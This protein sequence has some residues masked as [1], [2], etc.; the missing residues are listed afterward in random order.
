MLFAKPSVK[1]ANCSASHA[2]TKLGLRKNDIQDLELASPNGQRYAALTQVTQEQNNG[3]G[4][5]RIIMRRMSMLSSASSHLRNFLRVLG[6]DPK[7]VRSTE[8][9]L[10]VTTSPAMFAGLL[11]SNKQ[12]TGCLATFGRS[13]I[14][15]W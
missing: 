11:F 12:K 1:G 4:L 7:V 15:K 10:W 13:A 6:Q 5:A 8:S 14:L 2:E 3:V 9:T